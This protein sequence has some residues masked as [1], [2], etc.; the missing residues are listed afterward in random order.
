MIHHAT[1]NQIRQLTWPVQLESIIFYANWEAQERSIPSSTLS[2]GWC[3]CIHCSPFQLSFFKML[4][5]PMRILQLL[6]Y[7]IL[8]VE[9][10]GREFTSTRE[11]LT[12][13]VSFVGEIGPRSPNNKYLSL[14]LP[15]RLHPALTQCLMCEG[16]ISGVSQSECP[17][18][19]MVLLNGET[20]V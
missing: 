16:E 7:P 19:K 17:I 11:R 18:L 20:K 10:A 6:G 1:R 15:T 2:K 5:S 3:L 4:S 13:Q 9:G 12:L 14:G 8:V